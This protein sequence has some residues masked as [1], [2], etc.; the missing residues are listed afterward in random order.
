MVMTG[1]SPYSYAQP[2]NYFAS[3]QSGHINGYSSIAP[4]Q[5]CQQSTVSTSPTMMMVRTP[6]V[7][8]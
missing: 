7:D 3:V 4:Q 2:M 6:A 1:I 5:A 8:L